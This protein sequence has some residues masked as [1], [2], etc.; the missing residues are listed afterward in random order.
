[1]KET[2]DRYM[3]VVTES[4]FSRNDL[5]QDH[6]RHINE[7][8]LNN[9]GVSNVRLGSLHIY[10][11][12][13]RDILR[14]EQSLLFTE[15][16]TASSGPTP[17]EIEQQEVP[18]SLLPNQCIYV[19]FGNTQKEAIK[20]LASQVYRWCFSPHGWENDWL[21]VVLEQVVLTHLPETEDLRWKATQKAT[22]I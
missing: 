20:D 8:Y 1:M 15:D 19:G 11:D 9:P 22:R 14:A 13:P 16:V 3:V 21:S 18:I 2:K 10:T 4:Q 5:I 17:E 6:E 7:G 12:H